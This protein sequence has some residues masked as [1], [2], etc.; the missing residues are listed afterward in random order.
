MFDKLSF[1]LFL[2]GIL[3]LLVPV[4][5]SS[6]VKSSKS[7]I[8]LSSKSFIVLS[9]ISAMILLI[10]SWVIRDKNTEKYDYNYALRTGK[11]AGGTVYASYPDM[12]PGL[13]WI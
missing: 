2:L 11:L 12:V 8:V 10:I 1:V 3:V 13:G 9:N 7:F 5:I 6:S 4:F